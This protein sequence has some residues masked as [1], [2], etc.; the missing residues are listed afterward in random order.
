MINMLQSLINTVTFLINFVI[1]TITSLFSLLAQIP[2][3]LEI[4]TTS[5]ILLPDV[6]LPFS[7]AF[8]MLSV[9]QFVVGRKAE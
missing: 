7:M 4:I 2:K 1:S 9:I 6:V 5:L 3:F 8:I